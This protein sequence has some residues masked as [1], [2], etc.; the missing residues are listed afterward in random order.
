MPIAEGDDCKW[1]ALVKN[2]YNE[3]MIDSHWTPLCF[4]VDT[5]YDGYGGFECYN[6]DAHVDTVIQLVREFRVDTSK[7]AIESIVDLGR[8]PGNE[9]LRVKGDEYHPSLEVQQIAIR[10]DVW[11]EML[12]CTVYSCEWAGTPVTLDTMIQQCNTLVSDSIKLINGRLLKRSGSIE[13]S[14][15]EF[16]NDDNIFRFANKYPDILTFACARSGLVDV[17]CANVFRRMVVKHLRQEV[18]QEAFDTFI[19]N[20]AEW[21]YVREILMATRFTWRP[22][23]PNGPQD[24]LWQRH[25]ELMHAFARVADVHAQQ[26]AQRWAEWESESKE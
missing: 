26:E 10:D 5:Q 13:A 12:K 25:A 22:S 14:M 24:P 8:Y 16:I 21:S 3:G 19:R 17:S 4:P 11:Q 7:H 15:T 6:P 2:P 23:T 9:T 1:M 20:C 18:T